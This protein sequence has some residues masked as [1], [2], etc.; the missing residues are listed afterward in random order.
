MKADKIVL[1]RRWIPIVEGASATALVELHD[2]RLN[3]SSGAHVMR[4]AGITG[5]ST[6]SYDDARKSWLRAA[7]RKIAKAEQETAK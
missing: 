2:A 5:T 4:L 1:L 7:R 6:M 3:F